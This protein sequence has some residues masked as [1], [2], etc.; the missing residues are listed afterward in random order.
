VEQVQ[1]LALVFVQALDLHVEE[2]IGRDVEAALGLD[3]GGEVY[4]VGAL[5]GHELLL[6]RG[7]AGG[8]LQAP[9]QVKVAHPAVEPSRL[10]MSADR[11]GLLLCS[12]RRGVMPLVLFWNLPG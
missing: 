11:R 6:E 4:L 1:V 5:D 10:V 3:D 7:L 8:L 12:Q 2:R 9:Q